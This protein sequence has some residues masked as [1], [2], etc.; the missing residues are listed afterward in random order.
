[1]GPD[2]GAAVAVA[3]EV[4]MVTA[5]DAAA[6]RLVAV[7]TDASIFDVASILERKRVCW[8]PYCSR[9]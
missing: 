6:L 5:A 7:A 4:D 9:N 8:L 3:V 2:E 1:M